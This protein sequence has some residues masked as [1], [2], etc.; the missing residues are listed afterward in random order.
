MENCKKPISTLMVGIKGAG[1]IASGIAWRLYQSN[2]RKI[3]MMEKDQPLSVRRE[4]SFCEAIFDNEK[5]VEGVAAALVTDSSD[6]RTVW[7][8]GKIAVAADSRWTMIKAMDPDVIIDAIIAKQNLGTNKNEAELVIGVGPGFKADKD[9]HL[10]IES[11]RGHN[12][13]KVILSGSPEANTG[14]PGNVQGYTIERV[15]H[16][17]SSG[18]FNTNHRIGDLVAR[19]DVVGNIDGREIKAKIEGV[20]RGLIRSNIHVKAG[21]K[22]GDIDPRNN[23]ENCY[24]V[25]DK[26]IAIGGGVLEAILRYFN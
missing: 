24:T 16:A 22:I 14:I 18:I 6:I 9:V 8:S 12:L 17:P 3:F 4:V 20:L 19:G 1:D 5:K 10:A 11:K 26:A 15:L 13:G 2:I 21:I 23:V 25:S 7:S